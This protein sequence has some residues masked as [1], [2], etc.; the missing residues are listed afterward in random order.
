MEGDHAPMP[1]GQLFD[2]MRPRQINYECT[3]LPFTFSR[4]RFGSQSVV[5][6]AAVFYQ[7]HD[8][9]RRVRVMAIK[10]GIDFLA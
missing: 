5:D 2:Q 4:D 8:F 6:C 3:K 7:R 1:L 9:R 10:P